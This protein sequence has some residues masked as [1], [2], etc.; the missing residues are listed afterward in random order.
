M[1]GRAYTAAAGAAICCRPARI[2]SAL[3]L[4]PARIVTAPLPAS[5]PDLP[6]DALSDVAAQDPPADLPLERTLSF[7]LLM[8]H[9]LSERDSGGEF[10]QALG[11]TPSDARALATLGAFEPLSVMA[12]A[13][14]CSLN[15]GQASRAAQAL[16]AQGLA[17]K[18]D[19]DADGR[20]VVLTLT[21][22]GRALHARTLALVNAR[23]RRLFG[24]LSPAEQQLLGDL[25]D[26]LIAHNRPATPRPAREPAQGMRVA[27]SSGSK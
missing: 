22:A 6:A 8:L 2:P 14:A 20:G 27:S 9:K 15:K 25:L 12:L 18:R 7:R 11:L 4:L 5:R 19:S 26:R 17:D 16:V 21:P 10:L 3:S 23:S 1:P 13:E 24:C